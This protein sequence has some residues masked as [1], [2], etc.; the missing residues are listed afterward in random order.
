MA[1]GHVFEILNLICVANT[2]IVHFP[3]SI[4]HC[5][6]RLAKPEFDFLQRKRY[7]AKQG[8]RRTAPC[9]NRL[10]R[11]GELPQR[12]K[13]NCPGAL[14]AKPEFAGLWALFIIHSLR[15]ADARG[16]LQT[17]CHCRKAIIMGRRGRRPLQLAQAIITGRETV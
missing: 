10:R 13:R 7:R 9:T 6:K 14:A 17:K 8:A 5:E 3:L 15:R 1:F 2:T 11:E 16:I 4:V 12:G